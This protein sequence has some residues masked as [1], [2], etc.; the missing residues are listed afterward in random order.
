MKCILGNCS[1]GKSLQRKVTLRRN[2]SSVQD[3]QSYENETG[4]DNRSGDRRACFDRGCLL[5]LADGQS[6]FL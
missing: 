4:F 6:A 1:H 3:F 2:R 5:L